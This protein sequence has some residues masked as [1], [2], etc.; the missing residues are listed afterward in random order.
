[1]R[2]EEKAMS[3]TIKDVAQLANVAPSTVSRVIANNPR[4]SKKTKVRVREAMEELGYH[5]NFIARSLANQSTQIVGLVVPTSSESFITTPIFSDILRGLSEGAHE[6]NYSL[7]MNTGKSDEEVFEEVVEMVQGAMVDGILLA[8]SNMNDRLISYLQSR[9][10]PFVLIGHPDDWY[11]EITYV[12]N[13]NFLASKQ[14]T[15]YLLNLG[16]ERIAFIGGH[17]GVAMNQKRLLGYEAALRKYGVE[18]RADYE[19]YDDLVLGGIRGVVKRLLSLPVLPTALVVSDD[20]IS[21]GIVNSLNANGIATP[22]QMSIVSFNMANA[23]I[24]FPPL[25][26][27]DLNMFDLGYQAARCLIK[28]LTSPEEPVTGAI[29]PHRIV[30]RDSCQKVERVLASTS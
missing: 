26:S 9:N 23:E 21:L 1:M 25:T 16:H 19:F 24:S 6:K 18:P 14:A 27:I 13:D 20:L 2:G 5:P 30:E 4:I 28:K 12:D 11:E 10:F 7:L 8:Y 15:E 17:I 22:D 29:I 3:V